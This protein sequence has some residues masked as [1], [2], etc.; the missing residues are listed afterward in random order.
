MVPQPHIRT[1]V[2]MPSLERAGCAG[3]VA[4]W[5]AIADRLR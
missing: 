5:R 2:D 4:G 3:F 1:E